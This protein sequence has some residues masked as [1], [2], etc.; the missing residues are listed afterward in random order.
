MGGRTRSRGNLSCDVV[1]M[2][3]SADPTGGSGTEM[4]S[5]DRDKGTGL[6]SPVSSS[7]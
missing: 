7:Q 1:T 4:A 2:K 6:Y 5:K 3:A